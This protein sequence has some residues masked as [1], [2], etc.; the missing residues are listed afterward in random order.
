MFQRYLKYILTALCAISAMAAVPVSAAGTEWEVGAPTSV[1]AGERFRVEFVLTNGEG[2]NF[3]A[4]TFTNI[5]VLAGPTI[6]SG[7]QIT[8][9]NNKQD[10]KTT[11]TY[12][13]VLQAPE[14]EGK[15]SVSTASITSDG[16]TYSTKAVNIDIVPAGPANSGGRNPARQGASQGTGQSLAGDDIIL[17]MDVSK[18]DVFKGEGLVASLTVYTRVAV[19]SFRNPKYPAFNGFWAHELQTP[20]EEQRTTING[21]EYLSQVIRQWL[22]YPQRSGAIEIEQSEF[23]AT[24]QIVTESQ[25]SGSL[26]DQFFGMGPSIENVDKRIV[27]APVRINVK[28][29]PQPAPA[30]F[31]GAVGKFSLESKISAEQLTAN[32]GGDIL[33]TLSGNG[34]FPL[35]EA[36]K[37][38]LPAAFEQYDT[39]K[40]DKYST[41]PGGT[42]GSK[43]FEYPFVARA[44]GSYD[45]P[46]I[47]FTYFDPSAA[48]YVTLNSRNFHVEILRDNSPGGTAPVVSGVTKEDLKMLGQ[49]IRFIRIG[50]PMLTERG[51]VLLWSWPF[52]LILLLIILLFAGTLFFL[53]RQIRERADII[54]VKNKKANKVA[55][56]RLRKA[57]GYMLASEESSFFEEMLRALWGYMGDKLAIPVADLTKERMRE[58]L[59]ARGITPEQSEEFLS[60]ISECELAQCSPQAG[61]QMDKAYSAALDII[62]RFENKV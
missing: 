33:L 23:T 35:I 3:V 6:S 18:R 43:E 28:E 12:T 57:K 58:E 22:L 14:K 44:E 51:T 15:A 34:N 21:K 30:D 8:I 29:L 25:S 55:L 37:I 47:T 48:K 19:S 45:I 26:F 60:L 17:R 50:E 38:P 53:Q 59:A 2:E 20:Q 5:E 54:K 56:R 36:P 61:I 9:I 11:F 16:K 62:D 52:F 31:A 4:P 42:N 49:D 40:Y 27:T 7:T 41:A 39:K 24:A 13:Y 46:G 1:G 32:S 10:T